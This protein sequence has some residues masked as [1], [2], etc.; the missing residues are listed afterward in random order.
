M[1]KLRKENIC[2]EYSIRGIA[3]MLGHYDIIF[4]N[5]NE[6]R[7]EICRLYSFYYGDNDGKIKRIANK[8]NMSEK[9]ITAI[10]H[11]KD[12]YDYLRAI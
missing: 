11:S 2:Q 5:Y 3:H 8:M 4:P 1:H 7:E 6:V 9:Q 10:L 12:V